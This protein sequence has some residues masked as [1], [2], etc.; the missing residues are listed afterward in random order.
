MP[1]SHFRSR[2]ES[3]IGRASQHSFHSSS[4]MSGNETSPLLQ[5]GHSNGGSQHQFVHRFA[6]F[7][8]T[9]DD[10]PTWLA[11]YKFFI[12]GSYFNILLVFIPLSF[13]SHWLDWDAA[14]RF[15]FSFIAIM[16]LAKVH[17][18]C[19]YKRQTNVILLAAYRCLVTL[20]NRCRSSLGKQ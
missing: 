15:S 16:P 7:L 10:E 6:H 14:L 3:S 4:P 1:F 2:S 12:F 20:R 17:T 11:S 8:S 9:P 13:I 19:A 5:N 18:P